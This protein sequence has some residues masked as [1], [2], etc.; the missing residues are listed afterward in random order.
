MPMANKYMKGWSILIAIKEVQIYTMRYHCTH[1]RLG[2]KNRTNLAIPNTGKDM[3]Y[4]EHCQWECKMVHFGRWF[5][6]TLNISLHMTRQSN[7]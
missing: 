6:K 4:S 2:K 3:E 7:N 1:I 5:L